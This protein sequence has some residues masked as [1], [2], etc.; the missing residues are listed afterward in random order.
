MPFAWGYD[1]N[2]GYGGAQYHK[3]NGDEYGKRTGSYGYTDA[4]GIYRQVDYVADEYG[5]RA[6]IKTNEPGT[7]NE[8]PA[9][10]DLH[11]Y[12]PPSNYYAGNTQSSYGSSSSA[13]SY[14]P[15]AKPIQQSSYGKSAQSYPSASSSS[16]YA[17]KMQQSSY[18]RQPMATSQ[19]APV[20][21]YGRQSSP[22][23][24]AYQQQQSRSTSEPMYQQQQQQEYA[25]SVLV[26]VYQKL[27]SPVV[28]S[29]KKHQATRHI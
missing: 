4:Y 9:D 22:S 6:T 7:A 11:A 29:T 16:S 28:P 14:Q 13:S 25:G 8:S 20:A 19:Y 17:P 23:S 5:F 27:A 3:E 10:V 1:I 26:P 21:S 2:D 15:A 24:S 12:E 18:Q